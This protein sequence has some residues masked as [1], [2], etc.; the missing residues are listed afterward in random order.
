MGRGSGMRFD[1]FEEY[2]EMINRVGKVKDFAYEATR[3]ATPILVSE[4]KKGVH[5]A[6]D[7]GYATGGLE[8]SFKASHPKS[9]K[10]GTYVVVYPAGERDG[11]SYRDRAGWLEYGVWKGKGNNIQEPSPFKD[12]AVKAARAKCEA[13]MREVIEKRIERAVKH[14]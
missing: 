1:G 13:K 10:R 12:K 4:M 5:A 3:K 11:Y 14:K 2:Y 9:N 8:N 6:A 7:K